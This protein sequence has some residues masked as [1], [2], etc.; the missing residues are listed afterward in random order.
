MSIGIEEKKRKAARI[1]LSFMDKSY[2]NETNLYHRLYKHMRLNQSNIFE[3]P[4]D[5]TKNLS[6]I[7]IYLIYLLINFNG[8][9]LL[10]RTETIFKALYHRL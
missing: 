1:L 2:E 7:I 9:N 4:S 3:Y 5:N 8:E 10:L 6:H